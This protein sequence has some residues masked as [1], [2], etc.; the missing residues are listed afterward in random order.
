MVFLLYQTREIRTVISNFL[1]R[2]ILFISFPVGKLICKVLPSSQVHGFIQFYEMKN[3]HILSPIL[4]E[5]LLIFQ[6]LAEKLVHSIGLPSPSRPAVCAGL[7]NLKMYPQRWFLAG[8]QRH[9]WN[10]DMSG[11][12]LI[13]TTS[14]GHWTGDGRYSQITIQE[15]WRNSLCSSV[16]I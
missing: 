4:I 12:F 10:N 1:D 15:T 9:I 13:A 14:F 3:I 7:P 5:L 2:K 11:W 8:T 6:V 16:W